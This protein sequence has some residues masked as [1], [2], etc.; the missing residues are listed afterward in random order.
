M[1]V[2]RL[3]SSLSVWLT[4][5]ESMLKFL[6]RMML[7]T[8]FRTPGLSRTTAIRVWRRCSPPPGRARTG[9]ATWAGPA[10]SLGVA[11]PADAATEAGAA[12]G[13]PPTASGGAFPFE[14][15]AARSCFS[16]SE[17]EG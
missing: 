10:D 1:I 4:A 14:Y 15:G 16:L 2:I 11:V 17:V 3:I 5:S 7:E 8:R 9:G 6:A 12:T 13:N